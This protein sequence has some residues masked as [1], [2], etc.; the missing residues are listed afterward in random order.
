MTRPPLR[1]TFAE[2]EP[3]ASPCDGPPLWTVVYLT[4]D[5]VTGRDPVCRGHAEALLG[6]GRRINGSTRARIKAPTVQGPGQP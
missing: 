5:H 1:C 2:T 3:N 6:M 4:Q